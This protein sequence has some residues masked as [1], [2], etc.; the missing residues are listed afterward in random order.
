MDDTNENNEAAT[1]IYNLD[2]DTQN[3]IEVALNCMV[4]LSEAQIEETAKENLLIICD[5]IAL[6]FGIARMEV[7]EE[8]HGDEVIYKPRGGIFNDD[9]E[10]PEE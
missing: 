1:P 5:E 10:V 4:Q 7:V 9:D 8:L 3:L 6:R 2:E